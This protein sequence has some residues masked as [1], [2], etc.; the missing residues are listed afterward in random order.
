[1][2]IL[3]RSGEG[4]VN[5]RVGLQYGSSSTSRIDASVSGGS[6]SADFFVSVTDLETDGFN[7]QT[8][9]TVLMDTDGAEN[10]T[11]HTKLGWQATDRLRIGLVA[12]DIDAQTMLDGCFSPTTFE[13]THDYGPNFG[14]L[15][16]R[17]IALT[18]AYGAR[19]PRIDRDYMWR[20]PEDVPVR[21]E[22]YLG[23]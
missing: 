16:A 4:D 13:T 6:D 14:E 15:V 7:A 10:T 9:D 1:M 17:K 5:G 19:L 20:L 12:R 2:N 21:P 22:E 18:D 8:A 3:T 23:Y 11:L